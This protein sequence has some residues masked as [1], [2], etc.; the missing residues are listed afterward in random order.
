M[1]L[2]RD[3]LRE[4]MNNIDK[5]IRNKSADEQKQIVLK[6]LQDISNYLRDKYPFD[7][8]SIDR[9]KKFLS[10]RQIATF[11]NSVLCL[12]NA[13]YLDS[14][15]ELFDFVDDYGNK[16]NQISIGEFDM[17]GLQLDRMIKKIE[18]S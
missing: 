5:D 12:D 11:S 9:Q 3:D 18:K 14:Y 1:E 2:N 6:K 4:F 13:Q 15:W 10:G 16:D 7:S 17:F 8:Y